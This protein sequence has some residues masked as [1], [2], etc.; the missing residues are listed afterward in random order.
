MFREDI[1]ACSCLSSW[2]DRVASYWYGEDKE[3][4]FSFRHVEFEIPLD[5]QLRYQ[6]VGCI[7]LEF[8]TG[9][10]VR[11]INLCGVVLWIIFKTMNL[12]ENIKRV[13]VESEEVRT[14]DRDWGNEG[15]PEKETGKEGWVIRS[16]E[17]KRIG[18]LSS[19]EKKVFQRRGSYPAALSSEEWR[20]DCEQ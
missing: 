18:C 2:K 10:Q 8:R 1:L 6:I 17:A 11:D 7:N 5:I 9:I 16:E 19:Q 3:E 4:E 20:L 12:C 15:E 14:K 13:S